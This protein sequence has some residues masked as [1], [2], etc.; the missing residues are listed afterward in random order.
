MDKENIKKQI[1]EYSSEAK[2]YDELKDYQKAFDFYLKAANH[3]QLLKNEEQN[4]SIKNEYIK[5]A[6]EY[7][8]RAKEIRDN[9]INPSKDNIELLNK[10]LEE[11]KKINVKWEDIAGLE[12]AKSIL[13][14]SVISPLI[15]PQLFKG[16]LSPWKTILLY[17]YQGTGKSLLVQAAATELQKLKGNFF[18]I[19][20]D[21][22]LL[23]RN[24]L[25]KFFED[26]IDFAIQKKP[27]VIFFDNRFYR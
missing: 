23:P 13:K 22:K 18:S 24:S 7:A 27:A 8:I 21:D 16:N 20:F 12:K 15:F 5:Q 10:N 26:L 14:E 25:Y 11:N 1:A 19:S 6:K 17:G 3:L 4:E 9:I 2:K